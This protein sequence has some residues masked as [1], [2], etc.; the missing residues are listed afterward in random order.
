MEPSTQDAYAVKR[1]AEDDSRQRI[2]SAAFELMSERGYAG[3]SISM[4]TKRSG[5]PASST[6]W[7]FGSKEAL[8]ASVVEYS[9]HQW[10]ATQ[11]RWDSLTGT[12][13]ERLSQMLDRAAADAPDSE[14]FLR[15]LVLLALEQSHSEESMAVIRRVRHAARA[16]FRRAF[17]EIFVSADDAQARDLSATVAAFALAVS[18]GIFLATQ[19]EHDTDVRAL[20]RLLRTSYL[21]IGAEFMAK[22]DR[23]AGPLDDI[24]GT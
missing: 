4:I 22:R 17:K 15:I 23:L 1:P 9:A 13:T 5:L 16:G 2:I 8:L 19:I 7:H 14:P 6:Y 3:T 18:D 21:A 11:P 12:P 10:L 24:K 20:M